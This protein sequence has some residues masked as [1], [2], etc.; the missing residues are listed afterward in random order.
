MTGGAATTLTG[1]S[2]YD[3]VAIWDMGASGTTNPLQLSGGSSSTVISGGI[4][5]PNGE[6][7]ISGSRP[8]TSTFVL[9]QSA[10]L[11]N[12]TTLNVG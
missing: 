8:T 6:I 9:A 2:Q 7:V 10:N 11:S 1:L 5:V 12:G 3:N 4:Y